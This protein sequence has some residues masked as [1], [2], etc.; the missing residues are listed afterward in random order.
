MGPDFK[1]FRTEPSVNAALRSTDNGQSWELETFAIGSFNGPADL[2]SFGNRFFMNSMSTGSF[3]D[4]FAYSDNGGTSWTYRREGSAGNQPD[5]A[6]SI[7]RAISS[8]VVLT[9]RNPVTSGSY[10]TKD[11]TNFSSELITDIA[12]AAGYSYS[13]STLSGG[14]LSYSTND[15]TSSAAISGLTLSA[16]LQNS[17]LVALADRVLAVAASQ[18]YQAFGPSGS[19]VAPFPIE[20]SAG[21]SSPIISP[22][23]KVAVDGFGKAIISLNIGGKSISYR[24]S[25][26]AV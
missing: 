1:G 12:K 22:G 7:V 18:I 11:L 26:Y 8:T 14:R 23:F 10:L 4:N 21:D 6:T 25:A 24:V 3:D 16:T 15:L 17:F 13:I 19:Y 20:F 9:R 2:T 5:R